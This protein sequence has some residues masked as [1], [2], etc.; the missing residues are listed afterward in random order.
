MIGD[1]G[2]DG[3]REALSGKVLSHFVRGVDHTDK[4]ARTL[5]VYVPLRF[6]DDAAPVGVYEVYLSY[7]AIEADIAADTRTMYALIAGGLGLLWAALYR[8]VSLASRRLRHQATHDGLTG[9]PNRLLLEDRIE[10]ALAGAARSDEHVAVMLIDLDRFKEINDTLGHSYGDE[11]LRQVAPRLTE[12]VRHADT[13]ARLGG[14]E[15]A[16]LL[17]RVQPREQVEMVAARLRDALHRSFT[18]GGATLDVEA[19]IGVAL[20]PDHGYDRRRPS[21]RRRCRHVLSEGPQGRSGVLRGARLRQHAF[22]PDRPRRSPS[23]AGSRRSA[24]A[25][26]SAEVRAR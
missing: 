25:P 18:A 9:L 16:V 14:D 12:V 24:V 2:G 8:I 6:S 11:L 1:P 4:G 26:L 21:G 19:S 22:A 15:F 17:P 5:E 20:A 13:L 10:R 23:R 3:V 7:T